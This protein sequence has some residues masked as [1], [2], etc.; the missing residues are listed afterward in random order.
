MAEL[1]G[2]DNLLPELIIGLG[3]ALLIGNG[4]AWWKDRRGEAPS[5]VEGALFRPGRARFLMVVG[6]L[7]TTW[8]VV[9]LAS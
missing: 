7:M 9:T 4:L 5:G 6:V 2:I 3:L 8:G 1:L